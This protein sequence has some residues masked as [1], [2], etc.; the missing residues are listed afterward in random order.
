MSQRAFQAAL[1]RLVADPRYREAVRRGR[2]RDL[3]S[4]LSN[5]ELRRLRAVADDPGLDVTRTLH[6]GFRLGKLLA[7]LPLTCQL[8][9]DRRLAREVSAYWRTHPPSTFY[10]L[11]EAISFA[12]HLR[13]RGRRGLRIPYLA[14]VL[15]YERTILWLQRP[16]PP[17]PA[18]VV[19]TFE[20]EPDRLLTILAAGRRPRALVRRPARYVARRA[21]DGR[22]EWV[23]PDVG[24]D[25]GIGV[26]PRPFADEGA[27]H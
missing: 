17:S 26:V 4:A 19:V 21:D 20:V 14:D 27:A 9:G 1:A 6:K 8:L 3:G 13:A 12:D 23:R 25:A 22:V 15:R 24:R 10:F 18:P 2:L 11:E 16:W 5:R 7:F